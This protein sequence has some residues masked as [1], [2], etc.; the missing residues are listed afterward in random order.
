MCALLTTAVAMNV[1]MARDSVQILHHTLQVSHLVVQFLCTV[2]GLE[3]KM[4][5]L[6]IQKNK[7]NKNIK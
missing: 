2:G 4:K 1:R 5:I 6:L 3:K 7:N